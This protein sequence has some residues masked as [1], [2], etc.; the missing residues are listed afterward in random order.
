M[1][2]ALGVMR[3]LLLAVRRVAMR[4][5]RN[6]LASPGS[7]ARRAIGSRPGK[8]QATPSIGKDEKLSAPDGPALQQPMRAHSAHRRHR[9]TH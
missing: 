3:Q 7:D 4:L 6:D 5:G 2:A 9:N 8:R 1:L